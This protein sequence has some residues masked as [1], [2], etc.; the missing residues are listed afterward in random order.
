MPVDAA[1]VAELQK[2]V[3]TLPETDSLMPLTTV[4]EVIGYTIA[5]A[6]HE[7]EAELQWVEMLIRGA[8]MSPHDVLAAERILRG[9]GYRDVCTMMRRLAGRRKHSLTPISFKARTEV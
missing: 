2:L 6:R 7:G 1:D 9:L 3:A 4:A 8:G 5:C